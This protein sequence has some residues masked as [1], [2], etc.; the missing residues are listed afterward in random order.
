MRWGN[1][2]FIDMTRPF[3]LR[4]SPK[5]FISVADA[6]EWVFQGRGVTWSTHYI[7]D[8]L[9]I[10][11]PNSTECR[12]N[13]EVMLETCSWLGIPLKEDKLEG[14]STELTFLGITLDTTRGEI[15]LPEQKLEELKQLISKWR[16]KRACKKRELLSLIGKLFHACKVVQAGWIFLRWMIDMSMKARNPDHWVKLNAEFQADLM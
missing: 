1:N 2:I 11:K 15:W 8:F 14:P 3:G 16:D 12:S 9:A 13:L 6:L 10:G 4:S 7:D 5:I